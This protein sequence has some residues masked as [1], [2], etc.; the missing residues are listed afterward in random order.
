MRTVRTLRTALVVVFAAL[1][2]LL[3]VGV[4]V[5]PSGETAGRTVRSTLDGEKVRIT[6]PT[7]EARPKGL[8]IWFHGQ[9]GNVNDR[10][11]GPFLS[12]LVR[13]GYALASSDFHLQSWGNEAS[14]A[15]TLALVEWAEEQAGVP[16]TLWV[17]GSMGGSI[18]LNA[19]RFGA[20][21]PPCWY[22]V[23]PAVSLTQMDRVPTAR[24][25]IAAAYGGEVP[26]ERDPVRNTDGLPVDVRY[27]VVASPDDKWVPIDE[28]GGAVASRLAARGAE[29]TYFLAHGAHNDPSHWD[30]TDLVNFA[31]AC[32][33]DEGVVVKSDRASG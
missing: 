4:T 13:H 10:V 33:G 32:A 17:S 8:A 7:G 6:F 26:V 2:S 21:V 15:D 12:A 22:G 11:D 23:K 20:P 28:N 9:G 25:Y 24:K 16:V 3:V 19:M 31:N 18:S 29:V 27:R 5:A 30:A 14:T 1:L